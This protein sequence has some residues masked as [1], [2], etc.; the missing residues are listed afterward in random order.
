MAK[1]LKERCLLEGSFSQPTDDPYYWNEGSTFHGGGTEGSITPV[2]T[3]SFL[4]PRQ[5]GLGLNFGFLFFSPPSV[6]NRRSGSTAHVSTP[7]RLSH[8]LRIW[9]AISRSCSRWKF[10]TRICRRSMKL[11][12]NKDIRCSRPTRKDVEQNGSVC[13]PFEVNLRATIYDWTYR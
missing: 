3:C 2:Q 1:M 6:T 4:L 11:D 8:P 5:R 10:T 13:N 7:M 12:R 9:W